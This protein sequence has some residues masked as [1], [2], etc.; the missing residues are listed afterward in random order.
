MKTKI[1]K[2]NIDDWEIIQKLNAELCKDNQIY[3]KH[4]KIEG[5][6][7]DKSVEHFRTVVSDNNY[8]AFI[9]EYDGK[10][11]GYLAGHILQFNHRNIREG[12]ILHMMVLLKYQRHRIGK[13]L[14]D[15][16]R[17]WCREKNLTHIFVTSYFGNKKAL[18]F[19]KIMGLAPIDVSLEG[20]V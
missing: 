3:D 8:C 6:W 2:A 14:V 7:S 9:A 13:E 19:Y 1:R 5:P 11:V 15:N 20:E 16:F 18:E 17:V 4:L 10:S 12:E